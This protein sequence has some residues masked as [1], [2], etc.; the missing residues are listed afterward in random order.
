MAKR[1]DP[2]LH[3]IHF[4]SGRPLVPYFRPIVFNEIGIIK[5]GALSLDIALGIGGVPRGRIVEIYGPESDLH[6]GIM[7]VM[8]EGS[9]IDI[10]ATQVVSRILARLIYECYH[11]RQFSAGTGL[12][13]HRQIMASILCE[14]LG[15]HEYPTV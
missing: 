11:C 1:K 14:E 5:T 6:K 12:S 9:V 13:V 8:S 10:T 2:G 3:P 4:I 7:W 15:D